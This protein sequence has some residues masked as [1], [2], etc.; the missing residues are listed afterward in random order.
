VSRFPPAVFA[1]L[2]VATVGAFFVTQHLKVANPLINGAPRPDPPAI[3]PIAGR[4]CIDLAH[5]RVSFRRTR[6]GF[7]LQRRSDTVGVYIVDSSE[8]IVDTVDSGRAM[9]PNH[10]SYFTWD[11][12]LSNGS[13]APDGSYYFRIVLQRE[14]RTFTLGNLPVQ[15]ITHPPHPVVRDVS[16]QV[17]TPPGTPVRIRFTPGHYRSTR[18]DIFRTDLPGRPRLAFSFGA[19][20]HGGHG[21][22]NGLIRGRPA[23]AGTYLVGLTVVDQ[24]CNRATVPAVTALAP[25]STPHQGVTVRY[26]AAQPPS[27]PRAAGATATVSVEANA[28]RYRWALYRAGHP[29][30]LAH[31]ATSAHHLSLRLP[32]RRG[33]GLYAVSLRSGAHRALVPLAAYAGGRTDRARVLV[34]LPFLTWQGLNPVDDTGDGLPATLAAGDRIDVQRVLTTLPQ[35]FDDEVAVLDYL[36]AHH[37][38]YQLTTDVALALGI[39]PSL[40]DRTGVLLDGPVRWLPASATD[41]LRSFVTDGGHVLSLG[42]QALLSTAPLHSGTPL[43][44]GPPTAPSGIDIFGARHAGLG[45]AAGQLITVLQDRLGLLGTTSG[46]LSGF[47]ADETILPPP[48]AR[49]SLAGVAGGHPQIAGFTDG[50]G[51]VIEVGLAGFGSRLR[52]DVDA[53]ALLGRAWQILSRR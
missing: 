27:V 41:L 23:P 17:V 34:V 48:S 5:R 11:G 45:S 2:V 28:S 46:A 42:T 14:N 21:T 26:L 20:G 16:P 44:A 10:Y 30:V 18:V 52:G 7:F 24:A 36:D 37:L 50:R 12:R 3:N 29:K 15:V 19:S 4:M 43:T 1:A 22:W 31:G 33:A 8:D 13:V 39:G 6:L 49:A 38:S 9:R 35:E 51:V 47:G 25:G 40:R 32:A 53:Q